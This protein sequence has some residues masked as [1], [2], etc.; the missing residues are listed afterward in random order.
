MTAGQAPCVRGP[1]QAVLAEAPPRASLKRRLDLVGTEHRFSTDMASH[2]DGGVSRTWR[3][4]PR[5]DSVLSV[6]SA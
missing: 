1:G 3:S 2:V 4:P 5:A 6:S